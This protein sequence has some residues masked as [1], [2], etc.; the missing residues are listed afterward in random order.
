MLSEITQEY[1]LCYRC[2]A[3]S[4]N[5][6][7]RFTNKKAEFALTNPSFHPV[8]GEGKNLAV[9]SLIKP[10]REKLI[11]PGDVSTFGCDGCHGSDNSASPRGPHGSNNQ[12]ILVEN[13]SVKD[14]QPESSFTYALCYRCHSRTSILGDE[15][16]RFHSLHIKGKTG[17]P[18]G[19]GTSC[20]TCHNSHGSTEY[21]YLISF[22]KDV[23]T[24]NSKGI[25]KFVETGTY[26]FHGECYLSCHGVDHN[27]KSY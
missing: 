14:N 19:D 25:L 23:V 16:F 11:N 4:A 8:E 7:G 22:N 27:P 5:L 26:A 2:H 17:G 13:Y 9:V 6:P 1:E 12:Y 3:E 21:R 10:Y 15:S 20:H 24:P 18:G